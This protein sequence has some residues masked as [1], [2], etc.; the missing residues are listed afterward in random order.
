MKEADGSNQE[1]T[2]AGVSLDLSSLASVRDAVRRLVDRFAVIVSSLAGDCDWLRYS[3]VAVS[4]CH[5]FS[6]CYSP[7]HL[8]PPHPTPPHPNLTSMSVQDLVFCNAGYDGHT[9]TNTSVLT[10]DGFERTFQINHLGHFLLVNKLLK[11]GKISK[12]GRIIVTAS[13][14]HDPDSCW[15]SVVAK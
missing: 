14:L 13:E 11:A 1:N 15:G 5:L 10:G 8:T 12:I 7:L 2:A 4:A 3:I 9:G 6:L